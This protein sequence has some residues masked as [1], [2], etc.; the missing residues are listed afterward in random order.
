MA[1]DRL[2]IPPG[3]LQAVERSVETAVA[4]KLEGMSLADLQKCQEELK[5]AR[6]AVLDMQQKFEVWRK[7]AELRG[8]E[9]ERLTAQVTQ[10][11]EAHVAMQAEIALLRS[12]LENGGV[13]HDQ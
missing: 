1:K 8:D 10:L 12:A 6:E 4:R 13:H 3:I 7:L 9:N 2:D 5:A 11:N